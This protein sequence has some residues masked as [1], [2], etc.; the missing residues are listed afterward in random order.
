MEWWISKETLFILKNGNRVQ[1]WQTW[2]DGGMEEQ[3]MRRTYLPACYHQILDLLFILVSNTLAIPP[4]FTYQARPLLG[5]LCDL[6]KSLQ[7]LP[8][9][10]STERESE[11]FLCHY[12]CKII[13]S[14]WNVRQLNF[15]KCLQVSDKEQCEWREKGL[16]SDFSLN[17]SP[18]KITCHLYEFFEVSWSFNARQYKLGTQMTNCGL[19]VL[20]GLRLSA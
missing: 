1:M 14:V 20:L 19:G 12:L 8:S 9:F 17:T 13:Q 6:G 7:L 3:V 11:L 10:L 5:Q 4:N 18:R 15:S 2:L 16:D